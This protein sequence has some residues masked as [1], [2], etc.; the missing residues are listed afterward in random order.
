MKIELQTN[1]PE[2]TPWV[3]HPPSV[4]LTQEERAMAAANAGAAKAFNEETSRRRAERYAQLGI[5]TSITVP[6]SEMAAGLSPTRPSATTTP[7][8]QWKRAWDTDAALRDE[9]GGQFGSYLAFKT[10]EA[11]GQVRILGGGTAADVK[12]AVRASSRPPRPAVNAGLIE[13]QCMAR[14]NADPAIRAEFGEFSTYLAFSKADE[15]GLV[16]IFKRS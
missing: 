10:A 6:E 11:A 8:D 14:W 7:A 16:K 12:S 5:G 2:A 9:F 1:S 4:P 3:F 15:A 13:Q